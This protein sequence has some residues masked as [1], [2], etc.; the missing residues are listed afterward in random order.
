M[1]R[2]SVSE[3][4][5]W[6]LDV[7][8]K[9][10]KEFDNTCELVKKEIEEFAGYK[11]KFM[12]NGELFYECMSLSY[13]IERTLEKLY[14]YTSLSFDLDTR[15]NSIQELKGKVS[16]LYDYYNKNSYYFI[17]TVL[18]Y[19]YDDIVKFYEEVEDLKKYDIAIKRI[20]RY[21]DHTLSSENE[22]LLSM[23]GKALGNNYST[24]EL[25]KDAEM[26]FGKIKDEDGNLVEL[27]NNNYSIYIESKDR[28]VRREAFLELYRVYKQ[29]TNTY[30]SLLFSNIKEETV[31]AKVKK[32]SSAR[33]MS[34]YSDEV[35]TRV[36]DNLIE[37]VHN[38]LKSIYKYY[39]LKKD[40]LGV[41]ELHLYDIYTPI[42]QDNE[43]IYPYD[44]AVEIVLKALSVFGEEYVKTLREGINN[45]WIDVYPGKAKRTGGYSGGSYDTYPY[46]LLNYQDRYSDMSTLA[47]EAGHSMHSFYT[48]SSN[49]YEYGDYTIFV[50]EVASTVNELILANYMLKNSNSDKEK[51]SI[52]GRLMELYKATVYRQTM[53][54]EFERDIYDMVE[55]DVTLTSEMLCKKYYELNK[56]YFGDNVCVDEEIK[57][58]WE[59]IPHFYY[60]FY[61]YKYATGLS[62]ATKIVTD[63]LS[64]K[65]K[66][67]ENYI[68]FLKCGRTKSP[69]ESLKVAGVDLEDKET[70]KSATR[71]FD[72][73]IEEF[74]N[75]YEKLETKK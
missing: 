33:E 19:N 73:V 70:I 68:S 18:K 17:P 14:C 34:A 28:R 47:H 67:V 1:D 3:K 42:I 72:N 27:N 16:N 46:I 64:G 62:A 22:K 49:P 52:L 8:Y 71:Y 41:D 20:F 69:L 55:K 31:M 32:F 30:T 75:I 40:I 74:K 48:R 5:K 36:C 25:F 13:K 23:M 15:N 6:N 38:G 26:S 35:T 50:A 11:D 58:E 60:N 54:A 39:D 57:Y 63:I 21:K 61:V 66:A 7:I 10:S 2:N 29:Y 43:E 59:R 53:F 4:Y 12:N 45:R 51:L 24:Y 56:L 37:E 65:D 44:Q 9:D